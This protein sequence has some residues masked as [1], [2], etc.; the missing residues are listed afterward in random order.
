MSLHYFGVFLLSAKSQVA[1]LQSRPSW[2]YP[3]LLYRYRAFV[4]WSL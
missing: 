3:G 1:V 4:S 2:L